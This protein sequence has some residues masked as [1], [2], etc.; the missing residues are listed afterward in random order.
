[1]IRLVIFDLD[2]TLLDTIGDLA[3]ATNYALSQCGYP[4]HPVGAYNMF[5]GNGIAKLFERA[6]PEMERTP[7][8]IARMRSFFLPYYDVHNTCRTHPYE[9]MPNLLAEL[10]R[11]NIAVA[12][13]SNKYQRAT[14]NLVAHFFPGI[15]FVAVFGQREGIPVKPDPTIVYAILSAAGVTAG[16]TLYVGD[17][18]VDMCTAA[19]AKVPSVGVTWGFRPR[20]ELVDAGACYLVDTPAEILTVCEEF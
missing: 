4:T 6:L 15:D 3:E 11:C 19:A 16:E 1:M 14:E 18:N 12:V 5:V 7:E 8:N 13:A 9:G 10:R 17:S 20:E 2:G